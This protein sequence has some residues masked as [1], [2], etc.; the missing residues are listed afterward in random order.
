VSVVERVWSDRELRRRLVSQPKRA[1]SEF[2]IAIPE[3]VEVKTVPS[4]GSPS[5]VGEAS[6]LQFVLTRG[7][8]LSYFFLPS[9]LSIT[10]QQA[11]FGKIVSKSVKDP[12]FERCLRQAAKAAI[13]KVCAPFPGSAEGQSAPKNIAS[14]NEADTPVSASS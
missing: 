5:D 2:G 13:D 4:K 3:E 6:L 11:V 12:V 14:E 7:P 8:L 10:A 9:P 1:L